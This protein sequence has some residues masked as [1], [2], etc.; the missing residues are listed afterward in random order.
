ME[1]EG[2]A[3]NM[4]AIV[5][6]GKRSLFEASSPPSPRNSV[7]FHLCFFPSILLDH[8]AP[9]FPDLDTHILERA[10]NECGE[11]LDS[12]GAGAAKQHLVL[13]QM[14]R[15]KAVSNRRNLMLR[16]QLEAIIQEDS[17]LKRAVVTQQ[18]RQRETKD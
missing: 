2:E 18:K 11:D 9:I 17:L 7:L 15:R 10:I 13:V 1:E 6:N 12:P 16:Q 14:Q 8:L 3:D 5:C 4:S